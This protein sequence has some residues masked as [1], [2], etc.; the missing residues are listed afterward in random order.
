[1]NAISRSIDL[2]PRNEHFH[3][4]TNERKYWFD[5]DPVKT[6]FWNALSIMFPEGEKFFMESVKNKRKLVEDPVLQKQIDGFLT[7]EAMHTRE[8]VMYNK[9]LDAQGFSA[10]DLHLELKAFLGALKKRIGKDRMLAVTCALEHFTAMMADRVLRDETIFGA[11][12]EQYRR[13]WT[14]HALEEAEHKGVAYDTFLA[15]V[16]NRQRRYLMRCAAMIG[17]SIIFNYFILKHT[18]RMMKDVGISRSPKA[19]GNLAKYLLGKPGLY[20][21]I[22]FPWLDYFKPGFHPWDHDNRQ[23]MAKVERTVASW[24]AKEPALAGSAA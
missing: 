1:M 13:V 7:Q 19:W 2:E 20:R 24:H 22:F 21:Q 3:F 17:T 5:G 10:T 8:H 23:E 16:P 15:A 18:G 11:A 12:D 14:W 9:Q 4:E 6:V